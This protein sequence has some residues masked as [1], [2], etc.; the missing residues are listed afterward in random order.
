MIKNFLTSSFLL[1][2]ATTTTGVQSG[3]LAN[4]IAPMPMPGAKRIV[5]QQPLASAANGINYHGGPVMSSP[6]SLYYIWYGNWA[7][8]TT[9]A[10][11]TD[12]A[13]NIGNS[14]YF[15][16]NGTYYNSKNI[17]VYTGVRYGGATTDNYSFGQNLNQSAIGSIV[18]NAIGSGRLPFDPNG[19]YMVLVSPDIAESSSYCA[20]PGYIG[21]HTYSSISFTDIK[22]AFIGNSDRCPALFSGVP[23]GP[24]GNRSAD[25]M[26]SVVAHELVE[27]VTDPNINA[28]WDDA[29]GL[30]GENGDKCAWNWGNGIYNAGGGTANIRLGVRNFLIQQNWLN[31]NG[32]T[33][34]MT[35]P[36][37]LIS[38]IASLS[39]SKVGSSNFIATVS[40]VI[41]NWGTGPYTY[42]WTSDQLD[43][44][45]ATTAV[46]TAETYLEVC[47]QDGYVQLNDQ[48]MV[49]ITDAKGQVMSSTTPV[50]FT[51]TY[52]T[53]LPTRD[54]CQRSIARSLHR[55]GR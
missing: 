48:L 29:L 37:V 52:D 39:Q 31:A 26:A 19:V 7:N 14:P 40:A 1:I 47:Q 8:S 24:N 53:R 35:P 16:I 10:I 6:S 17:P 38:P 5:L 15:N 9:P 44:R 23:T 4:P 51:A 20:N 54:V 30:S 49:T 22:V 28:W 25:I 13:S 41:G 46:V 12:F 32:G 50:V 11:L 36:N 3:Q 33:C 21:Y 45:N 55:V 34:T 42:R 27:T 43:L 2:A 18:G